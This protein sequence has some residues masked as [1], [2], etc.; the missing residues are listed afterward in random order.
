MCNQ[1]QT[2]Y[3]QLLQSTKCSDMFLLHVHMSCD[4]RKPTMLFP[5]RSDTNQ[6]VHAQKMVRGWKF[7]I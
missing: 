6:A 4:T 7:W 3:L 5:N 1:R 2:A